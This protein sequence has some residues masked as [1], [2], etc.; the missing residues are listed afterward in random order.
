MFRLVILEVYT[1][2]NPTGSEQIWHINKH[3]LKAEMIFDLW[4]QR[5]SFNHRLFPNKAKLHPDSLSRLLKTSAVTMTRMK[6]HLKYIL[7]Y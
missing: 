3:K 4:K 6:P 2:I 1:V 7:Q 5:E